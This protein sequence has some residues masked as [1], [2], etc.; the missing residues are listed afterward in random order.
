M[1]RRSS[2][3]GTWDSETS[4]QSTGTRRSNR[5]PLELGF[6]YYFGVPV[7]NSHPPFVYVENHG[8]VGLTNDDPFVYG[9]TASDA[10]VR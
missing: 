8:V 4:S 6:D 3:S 7:L 5:E 1:Q 9:E 10:R 2:A